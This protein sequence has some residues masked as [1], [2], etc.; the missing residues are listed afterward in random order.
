MQLSYE[1][2][3]LQSQIAE[4]TSIEP[5]TVQAM[6]REAINLDIDWTTEYSEYQSGGWK[7]LS[8]FN[9][10]GRYHDTVIKDAQAVET[11]L[12]NQMPATREFLRSLGLRYMA[13]RLAK[14]EPQAFLWEHRD[15]AELEPVPRKRFHLPLIT[16]EGC[17]LVIGGAAVHM[18]RGALWMLDPTERHGACNL[19]HASRIHLLIDAY[20]DEAATR[21]LSNATLPIERIAVL[22]SAAPIEI[23]NAFA[24]ACKLAKLGYRRSAEALLLK[25]FHKY[26]LGEGKAYD[27]IVDMYET[28]EDRAQSRRWS[29]LKD[30]YLGRSR[31]GITHA[32]KA[33]VA[34]Q[35]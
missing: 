13:V 6:A 18:Q 33:A 3:R 28:L 27:L 31:R 25:T 35:A 10:T 32:R 23:K 19:G 24:R 5:V 1:V 26:D 22:P 14:L 17:R 16:N 34:E 4:L 20:V 21:L 9:E 15:Y 30:L 29:S 12:L 2:A 7:T 8:L 11:S